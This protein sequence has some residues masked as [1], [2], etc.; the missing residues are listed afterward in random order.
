MRMFGSLLQKPE[1][2]RTHGIK[3]THG[4]DSDSWHSI[5]TC[6]SHTY[7]K[8]ECCLYAGFFVRDPHINE[9]GKQK[10]FYDKTLF[11]FRNCL[12]TTQES[13]RKTSCDVTR[14][15]KKLFS[16]MTLRAVFP[17]PA[18]SPPPGKPAASAAQML[19]AWD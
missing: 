9:S 18:V 17:C 13:T 10:R 6:E 16:V 11:P 5:D 19:A 4:I 8:A 15:G 14:L 2:A 12:G 3:N 1:E 7:E